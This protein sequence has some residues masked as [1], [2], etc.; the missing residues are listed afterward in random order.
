M[1]A[2]PITRSQWARRGTQYRRDGPR[3][4]QS[5][6][7]LYSKQATKSTSRQQQLLFFYPNSIAEQAIIFSY[8]SNPIA[9][10]AI[11]FSYSPNPIAE[12]AMHAERALCIYSTCKQKLD[13]GNAICSGEGDG[14]AAARHEGPR[15]VAAGFEERPSRSS[16][17]AM[18]GW[19]S[20][21]CVRG[22]GILE[23]SED[24]EEGDDEWDPRIIE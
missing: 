2:P 13:T 18:A 14:A 20:L 7:L 23:R 17:A 15:A 11:L 19:S 12:L 22:G 16:R 8:S 6:S 4:D 10:L 1:A 21:P 5:Q 24:G 3:T 9:E